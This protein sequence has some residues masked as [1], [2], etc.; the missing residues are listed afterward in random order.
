[1]TPVISHNRRWTNGAM[2]SLTGVS[3]AVVIG[4]LFFILGYIVHQGFW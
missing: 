1:M 3:A 4:V 2:L